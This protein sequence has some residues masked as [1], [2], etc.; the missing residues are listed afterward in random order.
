MPKLTVKQELPIIQVVVLSGDLTGSRVKDVLSCEVGPSPI[1]C[2][3]Q[4]PTSLIKTKATMAG[5]GEPL[6]V[7]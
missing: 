5:A 1:E 3:F 2:H 4:V 7:L 6:K